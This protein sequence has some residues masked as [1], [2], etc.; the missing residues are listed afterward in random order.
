[1]HTIT[2]KIH[3][4]PKKQKKNSLVRKNLIFAFTDKIK[5][6]CFALTDNFQFKTC[7]DFD[8]NKNKNKAKEI[9]Q[10]LM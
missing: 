9:T 3:T 8:Y 1:M 10:I 6:C 5:I 4:F 2:M 7:S